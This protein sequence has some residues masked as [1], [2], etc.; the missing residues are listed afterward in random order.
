MFK[1]KKSEKN[2]KTDIDIL[3]EEYDFERQ[4]TSIID[5]K[6]SFFMTSILVIITVYLPLFPFEK[7]MKLKNNFFE[8]M[9]FLRFISILIFSGGLV[10]LYFSLHN[11]FKAFYLKEFRSFNVGELINQENLEEKDYFEMISNH[12][13][14][15]I[16]F[17]SKKNDEKV[18]HL[19]KGL[20]F[21][22]LGFIMLSLATLCI[23]FIIYF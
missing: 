23:N 18:D 1:K 22:Y 17:N 10:I 19:R 20:K 8:T 9:T 14:N 5:N 6:S 13:L 3:K 12:Y 15:I 11:F 16:V 2:F 4:R 7:I 21:F